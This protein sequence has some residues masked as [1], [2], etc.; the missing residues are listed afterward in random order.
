M[1]GIK[2]AVIT[3]SMPPSLVNALTNPDVVDGVRA[4][5]RTIEEFETAYDKDVTL[6]KLIRKENVQPD[7]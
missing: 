2:E 1:N 5:V 4:I 3:T 6:T 7:S